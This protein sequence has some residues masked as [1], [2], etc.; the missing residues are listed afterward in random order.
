MNHGHPRY[1]G[2]VVDMHAHYD[3]TTRHM[4]TAAN[5]LG[6]L[7]C[8]ISLWDLAWPPPDYTEDQDEWRR[9]EPSL[10]RCHV[11]DFTTVGAGDYERETRAAIETAASGG[12]VG[13][14]VWKNLGLWLTDLDGERIAVDDP[15]LDVVWATAAELAL[16]ILIHSGDPPEF[17]EP[18]TEDNP[19]YDDFKDKPEW[20]YGTRGMPPLEQVQH[21]LETVV[22]RHPETTFVGAHFGCFVADLDRWF[23]SYPNYHV[24]TSAAV[25]E[26]GKGDVSGVRELCIE[27][28]DRILFGT[29]LV[30]TAGE[31]YPDFGPDPWDE[32]ELRE[33][34]HRHWRFFETAETELPHPIPEQLPWKVTGLDLPDDVLPKLYHENTRRLYDLP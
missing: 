14:K 26:M 30:R 31:S 6:G 21:E 18:V 28:S 19:R 10:L 17:W 23:R 16:P 2:P 15:R 11:P 12:C 29:D 32:A 22:A 7:E 13:L 5:E 33:F 3:S 9:Y 34:F 8:A 27:W 1:Q 25:A 4:S 20:W 24:D